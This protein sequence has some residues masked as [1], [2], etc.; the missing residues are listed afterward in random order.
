[1]QI[2]VASCKVLG[3][4]CWRGFNEKDR[5]NITSKTDECSRDHIVCLLRGG[6][7]P[8]NSVGYNIWYSTVSVDTGGCTLT[9][10][11]RALGS[12]YCTVL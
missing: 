4:P 3:R 2:G 9:H 8:G 10:T 11:V 5:N 6:V 7:V 1:M 12:M